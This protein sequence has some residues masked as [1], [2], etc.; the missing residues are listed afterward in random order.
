MKLNEPEWPVIRTFTSN[1]GHQ[2]L[3]RIIIALSIHFLSGY[4]AG[5]FLPID[6]SQ[7]RELIKKETKRDIMY[8]DTVVNK[9][10]SLADREF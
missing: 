10:T 8:V 2:H 5:D 3:L 1:D 7:M 4:F 6:S 9:R